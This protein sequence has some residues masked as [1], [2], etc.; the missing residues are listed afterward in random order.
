MILPTGFLK[1]LPRWLLRCWYD[2]VE[3]GETYGCGSG[4]DIQNLRVFIVDCTFFADNY[5]ALIANGQTRGRVQYCHFYGP[6]YEQRTFLG[7]MD[8]DN[9]WEDT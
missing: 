8:W 9:P 4:L 7:I 3:I 6:A 5:A 2:R 1:H